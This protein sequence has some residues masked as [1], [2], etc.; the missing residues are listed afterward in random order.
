MRGLCWWRPGEGFGISAREKVH[1]LETH[2][3]SSIKGDQVPLRNQ[4][5]VCDRSQ[6]G[7]C[8]YEW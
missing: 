3:S 2:A 6:L 1:L 8:A 4:A 7:C 5:D